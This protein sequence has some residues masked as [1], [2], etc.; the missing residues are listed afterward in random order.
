M[1]HL[2]VMLSAVRAVLQVTIAQLMRDPA[3]LIVLLAGFVL[4]V[5]AP[6][7]AVFQFGEVRKVMIDT[8]L[9]S[10]LLTGMLLGLIGPARAMAYE[11]E[12]RTALSLLSKPLNRWA[13]VS[14]KY[15]GVTAAAAAAVIPLTLVTLYVVRIE[16]ALDDDPAAAPVA[17]VLIAAAAAAL[18]ALLGGLLLPRRRAL[19]VWAA[20][21]GTAA[22]GLLL[23]GP[24]GAWRWGI[25]AAGALVLME[26]AVVAAAA[27]ASATRFGAV[28]TLAG[29][30][31]LLLA[32]HARSLLG[33]ER[34]G[35]PVA[36]VLGLLPGL[37][38]L[39][40]IDAVA[41]GEQISIAY[42]ALAAACAL[43]YVFAMLFVGAALLQS[44][45]V[46]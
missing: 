27:T 12:D 29:G 46:T 20:I 23:I 16:E 41:A 35:D 18:L 37:E 9:S 14:G 31:A 3:V 19:A 13:L 15:L 21:T 43:L 2:T 42:V 10:A 11:L 30:L 17:A 44:R 8:G 6:A 24:P 33:P 36:A 26:V 40:G 7:Y 38:A 39:N 25:L 34:L 1:R 28:G 45:E 32:G 22:A 5:G 4:I